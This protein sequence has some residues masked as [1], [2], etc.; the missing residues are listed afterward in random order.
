[1]QQSS[2]PVNLR[3]V[4]SIG[5]SHYD[6]DDRE[7]S[8]RFC[9]FLLIRERK[10]GESCSKLSNSHERNVRLGQAMVR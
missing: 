9:P 6:A 2:F 1:M 8:C 3:K 5:T 7:Y 4:V 10:E